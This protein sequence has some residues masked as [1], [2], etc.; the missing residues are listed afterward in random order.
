MPDGDEF[1]T[2]GKDSIV[3]W[4]DASTGKVLRSLDT[5]QTRNQWVSYNP[6]RTLFAT[7]GDDGT[8]K[9]FDSASLTLLQ[10]IKVVDG[11]CR[12]AKFVDNQHVYTGGNI[13]S[14]QLYDA[15]SGKL[16]REYVS[17]DASAVGVVSPG[18]TGATR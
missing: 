3:R 18:A 10:S 7:A 5:K 2:A 14:E 1:F 9:V 17:P 13:K 11:M 16:V 15:A 12:F 6:T 8:L 4:H